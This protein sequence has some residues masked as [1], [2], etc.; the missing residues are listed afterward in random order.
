MSGVVKHSYL[1]MFTQAKGLFGHIFQRSPADTDIPHFAFNHQV[2]LKGP[3]PLF[4]L[5]PHDVRGGSPAAA[6]V[7]PHNSHIRWDWKG[8]PPTD[9]ELQEA[10]V[11]HKAL[12][13]CIDDD[14]LEGEGREHS[15]HKADGSTNVFSI[16]HESYG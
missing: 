1:Q 10:V 15:Q 4:I 13:C 3:G 2:Y 12:P 7:N 9:V 6:Y 14:P 5:W 16:D 11:F 8:L